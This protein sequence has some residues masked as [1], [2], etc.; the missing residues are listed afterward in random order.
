[1]QDTEQ[2]DLNRIPRHVA[3]I[4][5]GNGRWAK[6]RGHERSFGHQAGAET[7]HIIAE[8]A[9]RLGIK[10]LTLYTFSTEN[11]N[12]PSEEVAALMSLLFESIEE[13]TFMKNNIS[14]RIIGD[15]AKLPANVQERLQA[16][17]EHTSANTGMCLVLAL[18]YSARWEI[19]E[20]TRQIARLI[21]DGTLQPEQIDNELISQHLATN[22]MPDPDLL[23]RTGG[24][25]RLSNYLLWQCAYSELYFCDT[26]WPDFHAE[27]LRKAIC[28][29]Q[30]RERRFGKTSEQIK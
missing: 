21:K 30:K 29:Y 8:E 3:I 4:M 22:F 27:E 19:T 7:V 28:D 14:F 2:I 6:Q 13:E 1:M 18:S 20:A 5:D 23:I 10:Y 9:A 24:E 25:I 16:C 12:R 17:V 15:I 26:Y 11:W